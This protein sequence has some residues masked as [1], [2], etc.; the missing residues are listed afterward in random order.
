[1][2]H[3][4]TRTLTLPHGIYPPGLRVRVVRVNRRRHLTTIDLSPA[5]M[6]ARYHVVPDHYVRAVARRRAGNP[7]EHGT[8]AAANRHRARQEPLCE[9][10]APVW[11]DVARARRLR[12]GTE[13]IRVDRRSLAA[14]LVDRDDDQLARI[15]DT[16]GPRTLDTLIDLHHADQQNAG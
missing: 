12:Q 16:L 10:C 6:P 13:D 5:G 1:M 11:A 3:A 2:R 8:L 9:Q 14:L 7:H 4:L 15:A